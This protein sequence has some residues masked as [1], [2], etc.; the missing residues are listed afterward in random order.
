MATKKDLAADRLYNLVGVLYHRGL[1]SLS[2]ARQYTDGIY[3][4]VSAEEERQR[5]LI[6]A[7]QSIEVYERTKNVAKSNRT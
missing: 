4:L 6:F 2:D 5:R 7:N 1:I 3:V